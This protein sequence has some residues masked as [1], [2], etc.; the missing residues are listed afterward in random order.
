MWPLVPAPKPQIC[1]VSGWA[2]AVPVVSLVFI[3]VNGLADGRSARK[4][5]NIR[6]DDD[7]AGAGA[8]SGAG[9]RAARRRDV[10]LTTNSTCTDSHA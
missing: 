7:A 2:S 5:G 8:G 1:F 6:L 3:A 9:R 4:E 10:A